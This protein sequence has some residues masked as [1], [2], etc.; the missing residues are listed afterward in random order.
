MYATNW[1]WRSGDFEQS[2]I[3]FLGKCRLYAS[4]EKSVKKKKKKTCHT[5]K[6]HSLLPPT[7][8]SMSAVFNFIHDANEHRAP[9]PTV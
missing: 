9:K 8:R 7:V 3:E 2:N 5:H 1:V 4:N 6:M